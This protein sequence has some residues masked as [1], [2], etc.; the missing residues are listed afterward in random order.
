MSKTLHRPLPEIITRPDVTAGEWSV[1]DCAPT[2]GLPHT[3]IS[4]KRLVAPQGS[5]PLSQAVRAH[6]MVHIKVSPQDYTPWVQRGHATYESMIACEEARVNYLATK[7]G[8]DMKALADGSE[9]EAGERLVANE[10][11]EGAVRTAI[12]TLGSNAHRQFITGVRRHNKVWADVLADIGRRA[13]RELKKHDKRRGK[14]SLAS[15]AEGVADFTPYGF[16]Y[17]EMLANWVDRLCG[18]NP[19]DRNNDDDNSDDGDTDDSESKDSDTKKEPSD[20]R[21]PTRDEIKKVVEKY[22]QMDIADTPIPEWFELVV[23]TCPMPVI[24]NGSMGRKR[25]ASNVGKSPRRLHRYLTDPQ[26]RVFDHTIRGKGGIVLIDCSGSTQISK[27]QVREVL[28]NSPSAT[29]VAYTVLSFTRDDNGVLPTNAWVLA[30]NGRM[31]DEIPFDRG[32]ANAVDLPAVRWAVANRKR[33]EPIIWVTDGGVTG[34]RDECHDALNIECLEFVK[35][36][37]IILASDVSNAIDKLTKLRTGVRPTSDYGMG[38]DRF[39]SQV[40]G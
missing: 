20:T 10:D 3:V 32:S 22:K 6:E 25:V 37:G 15:T 17:T 36:H 35:R 2:R 5:D 31:V 7:A 27:D 40:F 26:R 39:V 1:S 19:N 34:Y 11:W 23:E 21:E 24:L 14:H 9:K 13:M 33:R 16:I 29:V 8:F 4:N 12:A 38:F 28:L 18:D 30:Q